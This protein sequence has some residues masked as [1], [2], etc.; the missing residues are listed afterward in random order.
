MADDFELR[1]FEQ[2][3]ALLD[4]GA[5]LTEMQDKLR[6]LQVTLREYQQAYGGKPKGTLTLTLQYQLQ[7][8][9][10]VELTGTFDTKA[11]KAPA[12]SGVAYADDQGRLSLYS[13]MMKQMQSGLRDV[14]SPDRK[15]R[16]AG[17]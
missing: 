14:T 12:A 11:P 7:K 6:E 1:T 4:Q 13:P 3:L 5:F 8:S 10:D 2:Q 17:E 16:S 15:M 9:G